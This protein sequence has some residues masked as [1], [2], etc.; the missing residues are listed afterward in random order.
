[1]FEKNIFKGKNG[2]LYLKILFNKRI[3]IIYQNQKFLI[4]FLLRELN[5]NFDKK[6]FEYFNDNQLYY[7]RDLYIRAN[8]ENFYIFYKA[9]INKDNVKSTM[10]QIWYKERKIKNV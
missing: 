6:Y 2:N 10:F 4:E 7:L 3:V 8:K 9:I 1:M 5:K